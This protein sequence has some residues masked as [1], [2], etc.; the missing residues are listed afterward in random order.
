MIY[1]IRRAKLGKIQGRLHGSQ[2][3]TR[4]GVAICIKFLRYK[5]IHFFRVSM[6]SDKKKPTFNNF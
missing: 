2:D 3:L 5:N 6:L 1:A 4:G